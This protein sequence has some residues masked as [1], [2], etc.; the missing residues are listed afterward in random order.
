MTTD[1][2]EEHYQVNHLS[3][4]LLTMLLLP[5]LST[6]APARIVHVSSSAH[7]YGVIDQRAYAAE[8]LNRDAK[9]FADIMRKRIE[10]VYGDTKLMQVVFSSELQARLK[11]I[12][13]GVDSFAVHPGEPLNPWNASCCCLV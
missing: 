8:V 12:A 11:T 7:E 13:P 2:I 3:H 6:S 9:L 5:I 4:V 10:G 1:G